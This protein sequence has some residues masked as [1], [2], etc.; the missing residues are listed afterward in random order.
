VTIETLTLAALITIVLLAWR[1][2]LSH[3]GIAWRALA[4]WER[5]L[6][7]LAFAPV[8]GPFDELLGGWLIERGLRRARRAVG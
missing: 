8:P 1:H 2:G 4:W 5:V 6:L 7:V 3:V